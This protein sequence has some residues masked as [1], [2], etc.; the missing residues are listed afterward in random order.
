MEGV[1][2]ENEKEDKWPETTKVK[3]MHLLES[4]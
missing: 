4:I 1:P 3:R 2:K